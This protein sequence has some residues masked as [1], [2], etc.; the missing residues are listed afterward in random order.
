MGGSERCVVQSMTNTSTTDIEASVAQIL[1][2]EAAGCR[3]VRLTAQG[4]T[5]GEA[6]REI[7]EALERVGSQVA[8]VADIHYTPEV[9]MIAA[10]YVDKVRINPGN[11]P[12]TGGHLEAL[13]E[14]CRERGVALRIGV[15]HGSLSSRMVEQYGDTAEGMVASAIEF[16]ERLRELKFD[17]V[18]VSMKSS[19]T[20]VMVQAYRMLVDAMQ[21]AGMSFPV[22]L[23]VTEAGAGLEGRVKSSVGI[24]ALLA[25]GIGDTI[26]VSL[27]ED[28]VAEIPVANRL[29]DYF[30]GRSEELRAEMLRGVQ[31][32]I[33]YERR[34]QCAT[35]IVHS[36]IEAEYRVVESVSGDAT[37]ELRAKIAALPT[38]QAVVVKRRYDSD[39][40]IDVAICAAA[41]LGALML[42]GVADGVWIDAPALSEE[43]VEQIELM[44]L[45]ASRVRQSQTEYISCPGC[46][47][48][49]YN[50]EE[51]LGRI[52]ARTSHLKHLKI[53][54]MGCIVN[55]PG[56]MADADYGYVGSGRGKITLYRA[57]EVMER[58]I[59]EAM[60][61]ERLVETI[62]SC[63]DWVEPEGAEHEQK[64]ERG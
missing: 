11:F 56:E 43:R 5:E 55:G 60:A 52:K 31:I 22:H 26:R 4:R 28:P 19:N 7:K 36:E 64:H 34:C 59:D 29:V 12:I 50:I 41:D 14:L 57:G 42:D 27:T 16:L 47:R 20:R 62:K 54:V 23:G 8:L 44:I 32:P 15:N 24:G 2:L 3:V 51:A 25:E 40:E 6:L 18:V 30:E 13:V 61:V 58:G 39:N 33:K 17:A 63:G 1:R 48:T 46:G 35:P 9:A 38:S 45:Q 49:L 21:S 10:K 37:A 53:G